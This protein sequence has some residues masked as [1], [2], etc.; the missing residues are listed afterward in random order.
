[1]NSN[2]LL[3]LMGLITLSVVLRRAEAG[4]C[5]VHTYM[6]KFTHWNGQFYEICDGEV[7]TCKGGCSASL[8]YKMH[9]STAQSPDAKHHC[10][11]TVDCCQTASQITTGPETQIDLVNCSPLVAGKSSQGPFYN[12]L[13]K[14]QAASCHCVDDCMQGGTTTEC[15]GLHGTL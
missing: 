6:H 14:N 10:S 15:Q 5:A 11:F 4:T 3:L 9:K 8:E 2:A 13:T 1:M 7:K 12:A